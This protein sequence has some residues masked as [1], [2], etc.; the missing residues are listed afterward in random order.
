MET[1]NDYHLNK[2]ALNMLGGG[3]N[4]YILGIFFS[5]FFKNKRSIRN[6]SAGFGAGMAYEFNNGNLGLRKISEKCNSCLDEKIDDIKKQAF[7]ESKGV[8]GHIYGYCS[9]Y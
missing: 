2:T 1:S 9:K 6:I 5:I 8:F 3:I 4:G 7:N